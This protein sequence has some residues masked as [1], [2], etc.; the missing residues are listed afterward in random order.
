MY[1]NLL[2]SFAL[3]AF[4]LLV[5]SA[6]AAAAPEGVRTFDKT[7]WSQM[8][9][10]LPRP[11]AVVFTTTDCAYCPAVI[12]ALANDLKR[13]PRKAKL[14]IVVM[15][16]AE[17]PEAMM[18]DKHYRKGDA[19]YAFEGQGMALRY[20]VNP[21]WRG[22]TPYVAMLGRAAEPVFATGR[23]SKAQLAQLLAKP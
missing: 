9:R 10:E 1:S 18:A 12:E 23:P 2:R 5:F 17:Q 6:P 8:K 4:A 19:M 22:I 7:T 3:G 16:G 20:S 13:G 14:V 21:D 11:S 15:D